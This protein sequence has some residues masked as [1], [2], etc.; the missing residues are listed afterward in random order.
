[1]SLQHFAETTLRFPAVVTYLVVSKDLLEEHV[2][3]LGVV[4]FSFQDVR[5]LIFL[6]HIGVRL[7]AVL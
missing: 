1:M 7:F 4:L 5:V 6:D 3:R 2:D